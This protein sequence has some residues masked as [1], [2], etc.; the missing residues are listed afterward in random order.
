MT[1]E[2]PEYLDDASLAAVRGVAEAAREAD[3]AAPFS[4]EVTIRWPVRPVDGEWHL[5]A[6][7]AAGAVTG[8][9]HREPGGT[10]E[11]AVHPRARRRGHGGTLLGALESLGSSGPDGAG[12]SDGTDLRVW[13]HGDQPAA[14]KLASSRGFRVVRELLRLRRAL[15]A[16]PGPARLPAGVTLRAFRPGEDDDTWLATNARAF[17]GHPEQGGWTRADLESRMAQPWFDPAGF[18]VAERDGAMVGFHWTKIEDGAG[19]IYVLGIDPAA[20]G[21]GLGTAL[22]VAGLH[23]LFQRSVPA[24][25]LYVEGDNGP[26]LALYRR[27]EFGPLSADVMYGR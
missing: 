6:R 2:A 7:D 11:L 5:L 12:G 4:E 3:G 21:G 22:A 16:E 20:Q 1:V 18:L 13:S 14:R 9:A 15:T 17:A 24:V 23:H 8:Y 19:E 26:A 27:L 10:A 25:T